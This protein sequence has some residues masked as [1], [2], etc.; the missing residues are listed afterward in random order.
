M[1]I[2]LIYGALAMLLCVASCDRKDDVYVT[3]IPQPNGATALSG[4]VSLSDNI[5]ITAPEGN[6][7]ADKVVRYLSDRFTV[8]DS[9]EATSV[10][11]KEDTAMAAEAYVLEITPSNG[12]EI[13]SAPDGSGWFYGVQTMMQLRN[14]G[15]GVVEA[16]RINDAPRFGY[17]GA[18]MDPARNWLPKEEVLKYLDLM[19]LYKLNTFHFHL[20]DDQGWRIQIDRYPRLMEVGSRRPHTQIGHA[21]T[22]NPVRYDSI[23]DEGYY[24]KDDI[25]EILAY[26]ADRFIT[27]IPEIE[28]PGHASAALASY[29]ELSCGL[30][31]TYIVQGR[32]DVFDEVFCPKEETFEFLCNVLDEVIELFPSQYIHIGG[33]ECPKKAWAKCG[34]CQKMIK[35]LGLADEHELQSYFIKRIEEH[36]NSRGRSIIGWDEILEGGLAPN[37]TVMSWRGEKGGIEAA[38]AGHDVIMTPSHW[39]YIDYYQED[40]AL[41]PQGIGGYLPIDTVYSYNPAPAA[42]PDSLQHHIIGPQVNVWGEYIQTPEHFEYMAFPRLLAM[43]EVGWTQPSRKSFE[44]FCRALDA[45]FPR[46]D[47]MGVH[48]CR[49]FYQA[50]IFGRYNSDT[51]QYE[52]ELKTLWPDAEIE[53][54]LNDSTFAQP[55]KYTAPFA[56]EGN[57]TVWARAIRDGKQEAAPT[58]RILKVSKVTGASVDT[59]PQIIDGYVGLPRDSYGWYGTYGDTITVV[60]DEP[61][62]VSSVRSRSLYRPNYMWWPQSRVTIEVSADGNAFETVYDKETPVGELPTESTIYPFEAQFAPTMAKAMKVILKCCSSER[63]SNDGEA[64]HVALDELEI[65]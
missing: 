55:Q 41:A 34:H 61:V 48:A 25:R 64:A 52:V 12:V 22:Y 16:V 57:A 43:A 39:C 17:R 54:T 45:E 46:L 13:T 8:S 28:M 60:F 31:K 5:S 65:N 23:P 10:T 47:A 38:N 24:T 32:Y 53:Y 2:K 9:G 56:L 4:K 49:N 1:N 50:N 62:E 36:V 58:H 29:P 59:H 40:P 11:L 19:A 15:K 30:G 26:A 14:A 3:V 37:A 42:I 20:T 35:D 44:R 6:E 63:N 51:K 21:D 33:D 7:G 27:V 18:Q